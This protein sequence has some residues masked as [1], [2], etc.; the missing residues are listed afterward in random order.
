MSRVH[1][2]EI[3]TMKKEI[4]IL[5][6]LVLTSAILI[7]C[8]ENSENKRE[9]LLKVNLKDITVGD[10]LIFGEGC[11]RTCDSVNLR[12]LPN[13]QAKMLRTHVWEVN[14]NSG[15]YRKEKDEG[16]FDISYKSAGDIATDNNYWPLYETV[17]VL[18]NDHYGFDNG[19][20]YLSKRYVIAKSKSTSSGEIDIPYIYRWLDPINYP[21]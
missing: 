2:F 16:I 5:L 7:C 21:S 10:V 11:D 12:I 19:H 20:L 13:N 6:A 4:I 9:K 18:S 14:G 17:I 1:K 3:E 8:G 15:Y